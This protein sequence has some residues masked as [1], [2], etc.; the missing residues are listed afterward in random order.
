V[1][2]YKTEAGEL[3]RLSATCPHQG[4]T[5]NWNATDKRWDCPCHGSQFKP[6]GE[7]ISGP[8]PTGLEKA[9]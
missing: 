9:G 7:K 3:I 4:C 1:A 2:V 5:V 6:D 8:A